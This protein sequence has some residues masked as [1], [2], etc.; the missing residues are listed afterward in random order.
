MRLSLSMASSFVRLFTFDFQTIDS[1]FSDAIVHR[2]LVNS[3]P[4]RFVLLLGIMRV[5]F[6][7]YTS[8]ILITELSPLP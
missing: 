1:L 7:P 6:L 3:F 2:Y 8:G 4:L 5:A